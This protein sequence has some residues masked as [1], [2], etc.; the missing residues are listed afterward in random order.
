M[1]TFSLCR[2]TFFVH[3][4]YRHPSVQGP[5]VAQRWQSALP[6]RALKCHLWGL[7]VRGLR[8]QFHSLTSGLW[9][10]LR[11]LPVTRLPPLL[12]ELEPALICV[13]PWQ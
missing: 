12:L 7:R 2:A 3:F 6:G 8:G 13:S 9:G 4:I 10:R 5:T 1:C 11:V